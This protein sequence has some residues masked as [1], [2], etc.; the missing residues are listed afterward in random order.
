M[1]ARSERSEG[2]VMGIKKRQS[3]YRDIAGEKKVRE[4]PYEPPRGQQL[5]S[6]CLAAF[7]YVVILFAVSILLSA[8]MLSF[9]SVTGP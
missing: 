9:E 2:E 3:I 4:T 7:R 6:G 1:A 5:F 8:F